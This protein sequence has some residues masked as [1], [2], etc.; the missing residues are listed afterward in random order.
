[1][2]V[3]LRFSLMSAAGVAVLA[4]EDSAN[5]GCFQSPCSAGEV[6]SCAYTN[7]NTMINCE[8][9]VLNGSV[10]ISQCKFHNLHQLPLSQTQI[11]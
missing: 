5:A 2:W 11:S 4:A 6:A 3:H 8:C 10:P 1:M 7:N 9:A